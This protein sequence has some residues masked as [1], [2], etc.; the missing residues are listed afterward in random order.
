MLSQRKKQVMSLKTLGKQENGGDR[1]KN[2]LTWK[3]KKWNHLVC[4]TEK[5]ELEKQNKTNKCSFRDSCEL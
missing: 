4:T 3:Q 5:I 2:Q 1:G